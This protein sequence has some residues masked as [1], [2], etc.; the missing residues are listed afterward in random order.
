MITT[1][2]RRFACAAALSVALTMSA[3]GSPDDPQSAEETPHG[4]VAGAEESSEAQSAIAY[5]TRGPGD[6]TCS[7]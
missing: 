3:C 2:P 1:N 7:T 5:A 6:C 4:Y